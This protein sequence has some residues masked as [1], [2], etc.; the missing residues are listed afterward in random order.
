MMFEISIVQLWVLSNL[1]SPLF[2]PV[3]NWSLWLDLIIV[4]RTAKVVWKGEGV[5]IKETREMNLTFWNFVILFLQIDK[6][7]NTKK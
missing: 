2:R 3:R 5:Q 1:L 7:I 4:L 6:N